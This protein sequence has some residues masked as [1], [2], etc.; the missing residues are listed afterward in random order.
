MEKEAALGKLLDAKRLG[1]ETETTDKIN[2]RIK[3]LK[4]EIESKKKELNRK[5][6]NQKVV[7]KWEK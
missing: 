1:L 5:V 7:K 3:V 6:T 4:E 2:K